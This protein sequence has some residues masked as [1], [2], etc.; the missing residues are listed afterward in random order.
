MTRGLVLV[1]AAVL[2]GG[3]ARADE[4]AHQAAAEKL[5]EAM[6]TE[7]SLE[8]SIDASLDQQLKDNP[9]LAPAKEAMKKFMTK[10]LGYPALKGDLVKLYTDEF[11]EDELNK[12]TEFYGT[13]VGKKMAAKQAIMTQKAGEIGQK[14]VQQNIGEL[15]KAVEEALKKK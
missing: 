12:L 15:T 10:H 11:S 14:R 4:K 13:P 3:A 6:D 9:Q 5:L 8:R 1:V 2:I 7:K